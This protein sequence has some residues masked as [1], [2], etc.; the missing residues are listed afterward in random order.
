MSFETRPMTAADAQDVAQ[1][2]IAALEVLE[3]Q[4]GNEPETWSEAATERFL[5]GMRRFVEV[6]PGGAWVAEDD[7]GVVGMAE[8]VRR[9]SFW[10]LA[11]LF[12]HPRGQSQGVGRALLDR[13][14]E[15][16]EGAT[17]RMIM[18]SEDPRA[19]RRYSRAGLSIN[20]GVMLEGTVDHA[21][22]PTDL[23]GRVGSAD[24]LDFVA[25]VDATIGRARRDDVAFLL[26]NGAVLEIVEVGQRRGFGLH[27][28]GRMAMLGA[29]DEDT[30]AAVFRRMLAASGEHKIQLWC[31]TARQDWAVRV[32]LDA[33]LAVK[34]SG[35]LFVSG[36]DVPGPWIPSGWYF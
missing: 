15:Y 27:R 35:P 14:L 13:T 23:P 32:G 9:D 29:T 31:L 1:V 10:G 17:V 12:V 36:M 28:E 2:H 7:Q 5:V 19:M 26:D 11:M 24:D 3:R 30:A 16:A 4:A 18:S 6:D 20:P 34:P 33:R 22:L 21:L 25:E 8:A